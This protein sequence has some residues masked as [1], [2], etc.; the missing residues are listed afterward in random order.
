[1]ADKIKVKAN[2]LKGGE[3]LVTSYF[4]KR[5]YFSGGREVSDFHQ[6]IDLVGEGFTADAVVAADGGTVSEVLNS[7]EGNSPSQGNF[8]SIYHGNNLYT[9][10]YHLK[11]GS[12]S[13]K[14]GDKVKKGDVIGYMGAT[15]NVTGIHLHFGVQRYGVWLDP[16]PY[17]TGEKPLTLH[18]VDAKH[19]GISGMNI[20]RFADTIVVYYHV[21]STG[22]NPYGYEVL[23]TKDGVV[24][25]DPVYGKGNMKIP[26][27]CKVLSGH[28]EGAEFIRDNIR[29][30]NR[31]TVYNDKITVLKSPHRAVTSVNGKRLKNTLV[32]FNKGACANTNKY[33]TEVAVG[34]DGKVI[35]SPVY[36]VGKMKIPEGGFVLSGHGTE[37]VWLKNHVKKGNGI[38][39]APHGGYICVN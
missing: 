27:G 17:L 33:G 11:K 32:V 7:V 26:E 18:T 34:K 2:V 16:L 1:M 20:P 14:R 24:L 31:I 10:Y 3:H 22:T 21:P 30:G 36:G 23:Y 35:S 37:S 15:G 5:T 12:V 13:V 19:G 38:T 4:G 6:G 28:G 8:V 9:V 29:T 25:C 39:L